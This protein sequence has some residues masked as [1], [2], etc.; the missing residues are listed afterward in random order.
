MEKI[1]VGVF[2]GGRSTEHEVTIWSA[3]SVIANLD[4]NKYEILPIGID[5]KGKFQA[6][7]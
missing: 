2:F 3:K 5:K 4:S 6:E 7:A 1:K